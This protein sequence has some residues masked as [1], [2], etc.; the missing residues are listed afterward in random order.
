VSSTEETGS[1][2]QQLWV[3][4][5]VPV[6]MLRVFVYFLKADNTPVF[7]IVLSLSYSLINLHRLT[8]I[9]YITLK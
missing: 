2:C 1:L 5:S 9:N 7:Y 6:Y 3:I 8:Q 4:Y